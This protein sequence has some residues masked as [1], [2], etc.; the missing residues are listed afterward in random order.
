MNLPFNFQL[1]FFLVAEFLIFF[2]RITMLTHND[3]H[4]GLLYLH[5]PTLCILKEK[6]VG[7]IFQL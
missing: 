1:L 4:H 3:C 6:I 7:Q 2:A 5:G